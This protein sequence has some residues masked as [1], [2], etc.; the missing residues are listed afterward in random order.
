MKNKQ[1]FTLIELLVVVLIIGILAGVAL[2]QYTKAVEKSRVGA[3]L[4]FG[5][6]VMTAENAYYMANGAYT[7][8]I[9]ALDLDF[10]TCPKDFTCDYSRVVIDQ[11]FTLSRKN[12][13]FAYLVI[14]SMDHRTYSDSA[15]KIYCAALRSNPQGVAF[16]KGFG[17]TEITANDE[18]V[19]YII[20]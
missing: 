10:K 20:Q 3:A 13:P 8:D 18:Y 9:D 19:R 16:C 4:A 12:G 17:N 11:K 5:R 6:A 1:G 15:G 7:T 2:P 14:F